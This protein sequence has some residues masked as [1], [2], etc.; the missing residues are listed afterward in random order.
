MLRIVLGLGNDVSIKN[1]NKLLRYR[2][3]FQYQN[4]KRPEPTF[5]KLLATVIYEFS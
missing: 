4:F 1:F 2:S 5:I 3:L